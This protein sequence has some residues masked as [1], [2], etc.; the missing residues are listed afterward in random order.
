MITGSGAVDKKR[1]DF[2]N[3]AA[4]WDALPRRVALANAVV[5]AIQGNVDLQPWMRMLD[6][7]CGTGL[8]T[9]GLQPLVQEVIAVD[10]S[11]GMLEQLELKAREAGITN[12]STVFIDLDSQWQ[13]PD[14]IDLLVSSMTIHHVP[15]V[16]ELFSRFHAV[17]NPGAWLCIA[18]LEKEDGSFHE[19]QVAHIPHQGFSIQEMEHYFREA[20]FKKITTCPVMHVQKEREGAVRNYP[21]NLTFGRRV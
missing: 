7:G 14:G 9:F 5:A 21:V 16:A 1:P 12:L 10:S 19:D 15:E 18:D 6:Y 11:R 2:D 13:L 20:G 4:Q 17:M 3:R 8:V